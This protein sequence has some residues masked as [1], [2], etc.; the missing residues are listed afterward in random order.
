MYTTEIAT[1]AVASAAIPMQGINSAAFEIET[2]A[3]GLIT[4]TANI[5]VQVCDTS[6]GTFRRLQTMGVYSGASG[7]AD[8]EVPSSTGA[9]YY[10]L[11]PEA[12]DYNYIKCEVS[13]TATAS[14]D[15]RV[16]C[17]H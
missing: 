12:V 6:D 7:I 2:F 16:H 15:L 3:V 4:A 17:M 9:R 5:Y 10:Q 8:W 14:I 13:N 11:P 1:D